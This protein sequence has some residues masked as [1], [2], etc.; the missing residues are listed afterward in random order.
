MIQHISA[1]TLAVR[2]MPR[3]LAFYQQ[4]GFEVV[5]GGAPSCFTTLQSGEA[6]VNLVLTPAHQPVWWGRVIFRVTSADAIY[7]HVRAQGLTPE[8][9][10]DASWGERYFHLTD[11]DGHEL[12]FAERLP[13]Q[14]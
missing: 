14:H 10:R 13:A 11:P 9:P 1:I 6:F 2:D 12:S 8:P 3:A 7:Q 4:L 5:Y